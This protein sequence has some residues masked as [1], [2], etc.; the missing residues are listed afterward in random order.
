M[1]KNVLL[2]LVL[3]S[4]GFYSFGCS[5]N[6]NGPF[7]KVSKESDL[8]IIATI[9]SKNSGELIVE[10]DSILLG[11]TDKRKVSI[12]GDKSGASCL[13]VLT[14]YL[15]GEK[16]AFALSKMKNEYYLSACGEYSLKIEN[17]Q[18]K[19]IVDDSFM[20]NSGNWPRW[21]NKIIN[22]E[23]FIKLFQNIDNSH[24]APCKA[25]LNYS[26]SD[27]LNQKL[28]EAKKKFNEQHE[29]TIYEFRES[30]ND[31]NLPLVQFYIKEAKLMEQK[32]FPDLVLST[33]E[34]GYIDLVNLF[35]DNGLDPNLHDD[36][37]FYLVYRAVLYPDLLKLLHEKG[38]ELNPK[39]YLG[40]TTIVHAIREGCIESISYLIK[41][42]A[43]LKQKT[44]SGKKPIDF[45]EY[46]RRNKKE[47]KE[48][49]KSIK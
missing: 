8:T 29:F 16:Y 10:I 11:K 13:E 19:G 5:C 2:L 49:L 37:D 9:I 38:A 14:H 3:F 35:L 31:Y 17:G 7:M 6:F 47:V 48:Y 26:P 32:D 22:Q 42:G 1:K 43:D 23:E 25:L 15:V 34:K 30:I 45:L 20:D 18:V 24:S 41:N 4:I 27:V 39:G 40:T 12:I 46:N 36:D 33:V 21:N 28:E 44:N